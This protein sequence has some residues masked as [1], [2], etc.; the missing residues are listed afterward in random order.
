MTTI[1][2]TS[3]IPAP[4]TDVFAFYND[5]NNLPR[6]S[7]KW[8]K[9]TILNVEG[10]IR[11]GTRIELQ[12][13]L[14]WINIRWLV[15]IKEHKANRAFLDIQEKGPFARWSHR[16]EFQPA[17]EGTLLTDRIEAELPWHPVSA[18]ILLFIVAPQLKKMLR[19]RHERTRQLLQK[20]KKA[21]L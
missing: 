15:L 4:V 7:P 17:P 14:L 5:L 13:G 2:Y 6:I 12:I 3:I 1:T 20:A 18:P 9:V 10:D 21:A 16:H 8:P 19:Y 11:Q